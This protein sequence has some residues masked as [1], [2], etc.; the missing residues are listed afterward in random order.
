METEYY[1]ILCRGRGAPLRH[2]YRMQY[3]N[4]IAVI[5]PSFPEKVTY[6]F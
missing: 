5:I 2:M 3:N 4:R 6:I 1:R